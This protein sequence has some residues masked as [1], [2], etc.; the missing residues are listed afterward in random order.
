M[1]FC[2]LSSHG[3]VQCP[4]ALFP[5]GVGDLRGRRPGARRPRGVRLDRDGRALT[6]VAPALCSF[7]FSPSGGRPSEPQFSVFF[8]V[9]D[10]P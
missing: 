1:C 5:H 2:S 8:F 10:S 4:W 7:I 3:P 9:K 6:A